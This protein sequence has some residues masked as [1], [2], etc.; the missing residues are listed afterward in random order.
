[1][2]S[3][4]AKVS[5]RSILVYRSEHLLSSTVKF[6]K[7]QVL[8]SLEGKPIH[9]LE[10][11]VQEGGKVLEQLLTTMR[12]EGKGEQDAGNI[13]KQIIETRDKAN[14]KKTII[15][16]VGTT[17]AGKSS[18]IN[19]LLD[20]EQLVP[21]SSMKACTAVVTEIS[22]N[23]QAVKYRAEF[24]FVSHDSW[25]HELNLILEEDA[26]GVANDPERYVTNSTE[27]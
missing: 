25:R 14:I 9:I 17:G 21:T 12:N 16:V 4:L 15:G 1:M 10:D 22:Y 6:D 18:L 13:I 19:A 20:E 5:F 3:R 23:H 24:E 8:K 27:T 2:S 26:N 7:F 11:A